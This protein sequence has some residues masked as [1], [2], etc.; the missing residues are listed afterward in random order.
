M[1]EIWNKWIGGEREQERGKKRRRAQKLWNWTWL[2]GD[3]T[4]DDGFEIR[5]KSRYIETDTIRATG[6]SKRKYSEFCVRCGRVLSLN[7][8]SVGGGWT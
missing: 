5:S 6:D 4:A 8:K 3:V 1:F 7:P 2:R